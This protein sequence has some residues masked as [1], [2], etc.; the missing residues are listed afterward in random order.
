M[1]SCFQCDLMQQEVPLGKHFDAHCIR[2]NALLYRGS[3]TRL[4]MVIALTL[5]SVLLY[6]VSNLFP[7]ATLAT[8]GIHNSTTLFGTV[9]ALYDQG[10]PLLAALVLSTT[11]LIPGAELAALLYMLVPLRLGRIPTGLPA[12][13]RFLLAVH[14]WSMMEVYLLGILITLI[15]LADLASIVPGISLWA[16]IGL[17]VSFSALSAAFSVRDFWQWVE[18]ARPLRS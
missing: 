5:A 11:I 6:L 1:I 12:A 16:F 7:V 15:K 18:N 13:F 8:Q 10:R 4:D 3:R 9:L 14:P 2:C 17:I